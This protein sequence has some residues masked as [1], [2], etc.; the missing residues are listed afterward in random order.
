MA[1]E[2]TFVT[3]ELLHAEKEVSDLDQQSKNEFH[4]LGCLSMI[5]S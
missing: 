1:W 4:Q 3:E 2:I 5:L